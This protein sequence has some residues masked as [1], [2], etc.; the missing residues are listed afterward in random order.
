[1]ERVVK[2]SRGKD[3]KVHRLVKEKL[4]QIIE[5]LERP[6]RIRTEVES[7]CQRFSII[8]KGHPTWQQ[9]YEE[10]QQL[11]K[12][13]EA[14][15][16]HAEETVTQQYQAAE[17]SF[18]SA[19][20]AWQ[21]AEEEERQRQA[22]MQPLREVKQSLCEKLEQLLETVQQ[23]ISSD[24]SI[25]NAVIEE[26][27]AALQT[28]WDAVTALSDEAEEHQWQQRF[29]KGQRTL[30]DALQNQQKLQRMMQR[31]QKIHATANG[32]LHDGKAVRQRKLDDLQNQWD[33]IQKPDIALVNT[34]S[35]QF[36]S[37]M[38]DLHEQLATQKQQQDHNLQEL[39]RCV[40]QIEKALEDGELHT[41]LPL[42]KQAQSLCDQLKAVGSQQ[43]KKFETRL[44]QASGKIRELRSWE[45]WGTHHEREQLCEQIEKLLEKPDD[46]PEET[47]RLIREAQTAWKKLGSAGHTQ[48]LWERF[49]TACNKA[50][51]PC[52]SY[53][54]EQAQQRQENQGKKRELAEQ[55]R[56]YAEGLD[57]SNPDWKQISQTVRQTEQQWHQVGTTDRKSRKE[58]KEHFDSV[59]QLLQPKLEQERKVNLKLRERLISKAQAATEI[60]EVGEAIE[61]VKGLQTQW[62]VT[63]PS[64]RKQEKQLWETFR[65]ACDAVFERRRQQQS[66]R[67]EAIQ[68]VID[69]RTALCEQVEALQQWQGDELHGIPAQ[70]RQ[71]QEQWQ[72][73]ESLPA[74]LAGE[75]DKR[76]QTAIKQAEK[77]HRQ[78]L[79]SEQQAEVQHLREKAI[80]CHQLEQLDAAQREEQQASIQQQWEQ[81]PHLTDASLETAIQQRFA[82]ACE[83]LLTNDADALA[84]REKLCIQ[85]EILAEV[86]SPAE[87]QQ[88]RMEYQVSRL[89]A[90]MQGDKSTND[91]AQSIEQQWY[92][93]AAVAGATGAALE[94]RFQI[95]LQ[96]LNTE[97]T[98]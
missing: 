20:Q 71:L 59:L 76:F 72:A 40:Q 70:L 21:Q 61:H 14:V 56:A 18:L 78:Q 54:A 30:K 47:A 8:G 5:E 27:Q 53:F 43:A 51:E 48:A 24:E 67:R 68:E 39:K 33:E 79:R 92:L 98:A 17:Q 41:A 9:A 16:E 1:M 12:R 55:L 13:W 60:E 31:L 64:H 36:H 85:M 69:A 26:Q 23:S 50:Y 94:Q 32:L 90:A 86:D 57:W 45:N 28:D 83:G 46:N 65:A 3:K 44:K 34:L 77:L 52:Q 35:E 87:A 4:D 62:K 19:Y 29:D 95:A 7:I 37:A 91:E 15:A 73:Q 89:S 84:I 63:V 96:A 58:L 88:A 97:E 25:D 66:E 22:E 75:L 2:A 82:T 38:Q 80:L 6:Q 42:E 93:T 49:N 81:L 10:Y 74:R 11:L